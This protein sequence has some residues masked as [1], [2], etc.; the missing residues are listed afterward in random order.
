MEFKKE[1]IN[2]ETSLKALKGQIEIPNDLPLYCSQI[3]AFTTTKK[4][5]PKFFLTGETS[6]KVFYKINGKRSIQEIT[7]ELNLNHEKVYNICKNLIKL[8]FV[9]LN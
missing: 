3:P 8:G 2:E 1:K 4:V 6:H 7:K 5:N 9:N